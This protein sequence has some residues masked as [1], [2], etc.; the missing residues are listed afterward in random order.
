MNFASVP[1]CTFVSAWATQSGLLLGQRKVRDKSNELTAVPELLRALELAGCIVTAD[2][3]HCQKNI[4][5]EIK[6]ADAD[7]VLARKG[8]QGTACSEVKAFLDDAI[9]RKESHLVFTETTDK[10]HGRVEVRRYWQTQKLEWFAD[11]PEWEGLRSVG[12]VE[13]RRTVHGKQ[14]V[15]RRYYL[16]SLGNDAEKFAR[17]VRGHWGVE[18]QL[19]WVLDVIFGEDQSR[20]RSGYAAEN[21]AQTRHLAINLLRRDKTSQR[22]IKGKLLPAA[23][24]PDY[25]KALLKN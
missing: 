3:L 11:R 22:G 18:N 17:A 8:N 2:A 7:Y 24:D 5:K 1:D 15:E 21:P 14:S 6:Q 20:A 12:V 9:Q 10:G 13:A 25:L 16:S 19:H 23:I 4:A